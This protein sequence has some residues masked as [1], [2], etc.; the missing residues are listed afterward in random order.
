MNKELNTLLQNIYNNILEVRGAI[1][2]ERKKKDNSSIMFTNVS[3][4][5]LE[6]NF[7]NL[8]FILLNKK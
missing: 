1:S 2:D 3:M 6:E 5:I 4:E 7:D 8:D